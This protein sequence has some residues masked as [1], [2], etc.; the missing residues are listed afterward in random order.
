[1]STFFDCSNNY[2]VNRFSSNGTR[3]FAKR[4]NM[5]FVEIPIEIPLMEYFLIWHKSDEGDGG[6]I[7]MKDLIIRAFKDAQR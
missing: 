3:S 6:H 4:N 1:M 7:W 5:P 2:P